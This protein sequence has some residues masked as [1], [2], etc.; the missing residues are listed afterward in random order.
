MDLLSIAGAAAQ[1][2][3][4]LFAEAGG[5]AETGFQINFFWV[6]TQAI[7]FLIFFAILYFAAFR[8]IGGVLEERRS[9][10]EQ[11]LKD[12]EQA[13]HDRERAEAERVAALQEARR[14]ANDIVARAQKV[15]Q[16]SRDAD[17]AAT[18]ADL[19]RLRER[20]TAEIEAEKARAISDLRTEVADL[21]LRAAAKVVG[22]TL[23]GERERRLVSE[24][25]AETTVPRSGGSS[26]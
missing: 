7:S 14:E 18:K 17:I 9:R 6:V 1:Q 5:E 19:E 22:E 8:R 15:A 2:G 4:S 23:S 16:E 24:F 25:L 20:A 13:R 10:I 3:V 26:S 12:A 11:G 21:A